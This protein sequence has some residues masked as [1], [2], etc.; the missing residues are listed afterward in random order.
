MFTIQT[1]ITLGIVYLS[2]KLLGM[3]VKV[4]A[5]GSAKVD[6][7]NYL[8]NIA[9]SLDGINKVINKWEQVRRNDRIAELNRQEEENNKGVDD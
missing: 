3:V 9:S 4:F 8:K 2:L 7:N 1:L 5:L 6:D